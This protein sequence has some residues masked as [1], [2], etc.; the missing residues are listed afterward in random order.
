MG[1]AAI[2]LNGTAVPLNGTKRRR[3]FDSF[4]CYCVLFCGAVYALRFFPPAST[5]SMITALSIIS[6]Y[7]ILNSDRSPVFVDAAVFLAEVPD[8]VPEVFPDDVVELPVPLAVFFDQ[9]AF[10]V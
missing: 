6:R 1:N 4:A 10:S 9:T 5:P 3:S 2:P 8:D 7:Q